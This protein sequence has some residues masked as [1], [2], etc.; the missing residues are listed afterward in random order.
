MSSF[1]CGR[2]LAILE[3]ETRA[4]CNGLVQLN[5]LTTANWTRIHWQSMLNLLGI[6]EHPSILSGEAFEEQEFLRQILSAHDVLA[7]S[8][9]YSHKLMLCYLFGDIE[10]ARKQAVEAGHYLAIAP[11]TVAE[12]GFLFL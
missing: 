7:L 5:Q 2:P 8:Y 3:E 1:W 10:E 12:S 6:G 9:F 4:Y 11:G